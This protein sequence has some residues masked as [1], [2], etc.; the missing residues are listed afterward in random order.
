MP[1]YPLQRLI[2]SAKRELG[3]RQ[4][5][6]PHWCKNGKMKAAFAQE[7]IACQEDI[8]AILEHLHTILA[9]GVTHDET[10]ETQKYL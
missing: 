2:A 9:P 6:Y 10:R 3:M 8:V 4:R 7:E 1:R 5:V